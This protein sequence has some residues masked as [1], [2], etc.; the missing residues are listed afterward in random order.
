MYRLIMWNKKVQTWKNQ[1][2]QN[3]FKN[4][5]KIQNREGKG[6]NNETEIKIGTVGM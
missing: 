5:Y 4:I 1:K 6:V 2:F 3:P